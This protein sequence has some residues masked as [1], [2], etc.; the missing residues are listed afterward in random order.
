MSEII[1]PKV[2][3][4]MPIR[5][6]EDFIDRSLGAVLAQDYPH[7]RLE[8]LI[9]DGM[10]KDKTRSI[11]D[12][13][14][15]TTNVPITIV[16]NPK[17]IV[18]TGFNLA[19]KQAR[20]E[21]IVRVDG[22]TIIEPD[23]VTKCVELLQQ[24]RADNVGGCMNA[25]GRNKL[26][27][28]IALATSSPFGVGGARFHYSDKEEYVDTVYM[29]AWWKNV[30]DQFGGF[31]EEFIRNQDDEFNY[32]LRSSGGRILLSPFIKSTYY[33]RSTLG[34]LWKQY[35]QY[36][37]Y[38][39]RVMQKHPLQ[40]RARQF[41]PSALVG[42]TMLGLLSIAF[43]KWLFI[44][45]L[46]GF[47]AYILVNLIFSFLISYKHSIYYVFYLPTIF[48]ILHYS[49]G[50]GFWHGLIRFRKNWS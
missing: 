44:V 5:N 30:F 46:I 39:V 37:M 17:Q 29:G 16:D 15:K 7:H 25:V 6:E 1:L 32:R 10:S 20:G 47:I 43:N 31:D 18:P 26:G 2:S 35:Y 14:S 3:I 40:M 28:A 21:I 24:N 4:I 34:S 48:F 12:T 22:H 41:V 45:C 11:I 38:K 23:Y 36:G 50:I 33:N 27:K 49:Y 13:L 8:V 19:L 9:A 42:I